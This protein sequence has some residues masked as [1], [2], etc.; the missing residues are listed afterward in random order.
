MK[1]VDEKYEYEIGDTGPAGGLV[2]YDKGS[3]SGGW[4]YL[5]AAPESTEQRICWEEAIEYCKN[6]VHNGYN[7]WY[8]PSKDELDEM[9]KNLHRQKLGG[10]ADDNY[11]SSSEGNGGSAWAQSFGIGYQ[12]SNG[13]NSNRRVRAA[14]AF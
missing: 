12:G 4:R 3:Y 10:F 11:W 7:D 8:L 1:L 9:Y 14:R 2:F 13:K 5:E 6:M